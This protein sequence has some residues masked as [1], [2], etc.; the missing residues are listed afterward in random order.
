MCLVYIQ[1]PPVWAILPLS[2]LPQ[3][4]VGKAWDLYAQCLGIPAGLHHW[5]ASYNIWKAEEKEKQSNAPTTA[6]CRHGPLAGGSPGFPLPWGTIRDVPTSGLLGSKAVAP[7]IYVKAPS[8]SGILMKAPAWVLEMTDTFA[9]QDLQRRP[10]PSQP[11]FPNSL[12]PAT[13]LLF[14]EIL[15]WCFD[16]WLNPNWKKSTYSA[17]FHNP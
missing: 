14:F 15:K 1:Y 9:F 12:Q 13:D 17:Y 8:T 4:R 7:E 5:K 2:P 10:A 11:R 3:S 6:E 16:S